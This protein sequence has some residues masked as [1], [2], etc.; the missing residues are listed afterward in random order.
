MSYRLTIVV[1]VYNE[2]ENLLRVETVFLKY[3]ETATAKSK[4]LFVS[5]SSMIFVSVV[6]ILNSFLSKRIAV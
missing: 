5:N 3:F 2:E 4:V 6:P 1:P